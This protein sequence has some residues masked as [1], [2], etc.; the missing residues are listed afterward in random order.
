VTT[1]PSAEPIGALPAIEPEESR[2]AIFWRFLKF[3]CLAWA[4][5]RRRS[6]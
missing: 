1:G 3:G 4:G 2:A 5:R 6:R